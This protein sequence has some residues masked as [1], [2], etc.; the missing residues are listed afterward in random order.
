MKIK[1]LPLDKSL[2]GVRFIYP[3]DGEKYYWASQWSKGVWGKL[4]PD[5]ERVFPLFVEDIQEALKWEVVP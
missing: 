3:G 2:K 1:D 4:H 5:E